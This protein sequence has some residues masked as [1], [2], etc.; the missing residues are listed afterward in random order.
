[1]SCAT[2]WAARKISFESRTI[3]YLHV[4]R[5]LPRRRLVSINFP[6]LGSRSALSSINM[7]VV[8]P[9]RQIV[10][11]FRLACLVASFTA[12]ADDAV[13]RLA[14]RQP[15]LCEIGPVIQVAATR[16]VR[17]SNRSTSFHVSRF[18]NG[19]SRH[20]FPSP[21]VSLIAIS[22]H[23]FFQRLLSRGS[24]RGDGGS[25]NG[26]VKGQIVSC[27]LCAWQLRLAWTTPTVWIRSDVWRSGDT[28]TGGRSLR[29]DGERDA[30]YIRAS[31]AFAWCA[32]L[33][34]FDTWDVRLKYVR[35]LHRPP[36]YPSLSLIL[37]FERV[38]KKKKGQIVEATF[39]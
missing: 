21:I 30:K 28:Y 26:R 10:H 31:Y 33:R 16:I 17:I 2:R 8:P 39:A 9:S 4:F 20:R 3:R 23:Y 12:S 27:T 38:E 14:T 24:P 35:L 29:S 6:T 36:L 1:M 32:L 19:R 34:R 5:A 25:D 22:E 18:T 37:P 7:R 11:C 13:A 15:N